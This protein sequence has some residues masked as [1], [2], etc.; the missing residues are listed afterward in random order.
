MSLTKTIHPKSLHL[1]FFCLSYTLTK[2]LIH[3]KMV[4][5]RKTLPKYL[6]RC[7][8]TLQGSIEI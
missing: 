2:I 8:L 1:R 4:H 5:K 7:F 6:K 3:K